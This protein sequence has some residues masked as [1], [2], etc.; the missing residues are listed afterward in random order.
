MSYQS[1]HNYGYGI[2]TD[3]LEIADVSRI[4]ALLQCAPEYEKKAERQLQERGITDPDADDY[5]ELEM[6]GCYGIASLMEGVILEAEGL[7]FTA[8]N[9]YESTNYLLYMPTYPWYLNPKEQGL[10]EESIRQIFAKYV[11]ILSDEELEV[12]YQSVENGG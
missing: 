5:L 8:C 4:K 7:Q 3:S 10:T 2:C 1:W 12:E 6:S 9:N 11:S